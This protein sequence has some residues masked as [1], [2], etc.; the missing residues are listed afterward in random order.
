MSAK[1]SLGHKACRKIHKDI[2]NSTN[3][4]SLTITLKPYFNKDP[5]NIQYRQL[6]QDVIALLHKLDRYYNII[7]LSPEFTKDFNVHYHCYFILPDDMDIISFEQNF[8]RLRTKKGSIGSNYK[9]KQI[10]SVSKEL[11]DYPFKDIDRTLRYSKVDNCL[12]NPY[13]SVL[14]GRNPWKII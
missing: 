1:Y 14:M 7:M 2:V 12:F 3:G 6:T 4:Y 10:D 11:L 13:H 5:V 9:L 8:K